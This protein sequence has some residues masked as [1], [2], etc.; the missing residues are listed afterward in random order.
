MVSEIDTNKKVES[1]PDGVKS[2]E[3]PDLKAA[4]LLTSPGN[5][6]KSGI[7]ETTRE[8]DY[9]NAVLG[10]VDVVANPLAGKA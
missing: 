5:A 10:A 2:G 3:A 6:A 7:A 4:E 8:R 9:A 1:K